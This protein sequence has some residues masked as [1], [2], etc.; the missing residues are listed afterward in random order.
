MKK[1]RYRTKTEGFDQS[2]FQDMEKGLKYRMV[3]FLYGLK[4]PI[5]Y[6]ELS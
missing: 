2:K 3:L 5:V 6:D 1:C 4:I